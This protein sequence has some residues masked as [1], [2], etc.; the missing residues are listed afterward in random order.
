[1]V[2][3]R[4][5]YCHGGLTRDE[6]VF[7]ASWLAPHHGDCHSEHGHC[8]GPG[9]QEPRTGRPWQEPD[10]AVLRTLRVCQ[11]HLALL[12]GA[13]LT[14][15]GVGVG[16]GLNSETT[17]AVT[18]PSEPRPSPSEPRP[19]GS[20]LRPSDPPPLECAQP[21]EPQPLR[22]AAHGL[23]L[24]TRGFS[25]P[26]CLA[27]G[28]RLLLRRES[29]GY[30]HVFLVPAEDA[31]PWRRPQPVMVVEPG[32]PIAL[33]GP[34][35][36]SHVLAPRGPSETYLAPVADGGLDMVEIVR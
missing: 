18:T 22:F 10:S 34:G 16:W 15:A 33:V 14:L 6:A 11:R 24:E 3:V 29:G 27:A 25:Y 2:T 12:V 26:V 23:R 9:C 19:S 8:A 30:T 28:E 5:T 4:C 7:C 17:P 31:P 1:L 13:L 21:A 32:D 35:G 20:G 36:L